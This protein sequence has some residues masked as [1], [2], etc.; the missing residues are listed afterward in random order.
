[1]KKRISLLLVF[2]LVLSMAACAKTPATTNPTG[3]TPGVIETK[4]NET[5]PTEG[6]PTQPKPTEPAPTEAPWT[7]VADAAGL[8]KVLEEVGK[9]KVTADIST[10]S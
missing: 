2:A 3:T 7:E 6:Q 5:K 8:K 1:M 9:A 10:D 4:P